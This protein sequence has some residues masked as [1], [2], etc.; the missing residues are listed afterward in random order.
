MFEINEVP[1]EDT[2]CEAFSGLFTRVCLTADN[3]RLKKASFNSTA[4]P[5]TVFDESEAGVESFLDGKNTPDGRDGSIL[6]FWVNK[7]GG[8]KKLEEEF[9]KRVRQGILVVPGTRVF[10]RND[11]DNQFSTMEKIGHCGDGYEWIEERF[12]REVINIPIMMGEFLIEE[13]L[14]FGEG[15][16]GGNIWIYCDSYESGV[17]AGEVALNSIKEVDGVIT[18]FDICSAGSK[19]ETNYPDI[20]PTTNHPYCP[21]LSNKIEDSRV[22]KNVE[23]IPEI[24][25]NGVSEEAVKDAM[26]AGIKSATEVDGV[27]RVGAGNFGGDLGS[28]NISLKQLFSD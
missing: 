20:G 3:D 18:P 27:V 25:I 16:M 10:N 8:I 17:K 19:V 14:G 23:S 5:L 9:A 15:V 26:I 24:V 1:I 6:Q 7:K 11:F 4:L 28:Y 21:T 22:P 13:K 2:Y 12:G